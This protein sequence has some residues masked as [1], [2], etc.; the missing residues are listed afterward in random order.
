MFANAPVLKNGNLTNT[1]I[2]PLYKTLKDFSD[3]VVSSS[4]GD[5][6]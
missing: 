5:Q 2:S 3:S 4:R 1:E 6:T